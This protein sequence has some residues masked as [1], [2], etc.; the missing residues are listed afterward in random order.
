VIEPLSEISWTGIYIASCLYTS[1]VGTA[2]AW[3]LWLGLVRAGEE[4]R[5]SACVYFVPRVSVLLGALFV[6]E[7][8][9]PLL[10]VGA[11]LVVSGILLVN[12]QSTVVVQE[13]EK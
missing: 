1:L 12:K 11:A 4:R 10:L 8:V 2:C 3:L 9:G 5:A 13:P 6:G 7:T